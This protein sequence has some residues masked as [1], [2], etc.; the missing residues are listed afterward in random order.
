MFS[1]K[2]TVYLKVY[3]MGNDLTKKLKRERKAY[4]HI[5]KLS[6]HNAR[7]PQLGSGFSLAFVPQIEF[8]TTLKSSDFLFSQFP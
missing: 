1:L 7:A 5:K 2:E 8:S 3:E 4:T 6:A